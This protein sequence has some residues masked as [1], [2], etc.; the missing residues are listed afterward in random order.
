VFSGFITSILTAKDGTVWTAGSQCCGAGAGGY[1]AQVPAVA[2]ENAFA[3]DIST[4]PGGD[5]WG[6]LVHNGPIYQ[7]APDGTVLNTYALPAGSVIE[8][9]HAIV[10]GADGAL[11]FTDAGNNAIARLAPGGQIAEFKVPT[12]NSGV[13]SITLAADGGMWFTESTADKIGRIDSSGKIYEFAVP[14]ANAQPTAIAAASP[15]CACST[16]EVWFTETG[17]DKIASVT[18]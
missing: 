17:S 2:A 9:S 13:Q 1:P 18:Y 5:V 15:S 7:F 6:I 8:G 16:S 3:L 10:E 4:G 12:P 14:T 11:W